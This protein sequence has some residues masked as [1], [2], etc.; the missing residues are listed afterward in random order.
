MSPLFLAFALVLAALL[1]Y[2][3]ATFGEAFIGLC[4]PR[5]ETLFLLLCAGLVIAVQLDGP[6]RGMAVLTMMLPVRVERL[7]ELLY[8][9]QGHGHDAAKRAWPARP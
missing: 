9:T 2:R 3:P 4:A 7:F 6:I 5:I 1:L 8:G